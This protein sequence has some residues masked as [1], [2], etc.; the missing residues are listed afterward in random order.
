MKKLL[1]GLATLSMALSLVACGGD[2]GTAGTTGTPTTGTET[3]AVTGGTYVVQ[4]SGEP[5]TLNPD[6]VSEDN[7]YAI[8]QNIFGRLVKLTNDYTAIPDLADLP[9]VSEDA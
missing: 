2:T 9:E 7:N 6:S 8:A 1:C 5:A 3:G 4:Q